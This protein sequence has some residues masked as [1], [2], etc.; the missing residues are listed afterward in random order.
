TIM[1]GSW[2]VGLF[3][4]L[5]RVPSH[6]GAFILFPGSY[7]NYRRLFSVSPEV[8]KSQVSPIEN[9]GPYMEFLAEPGDAVIF[10]HAMGHTGSTNITNPQTRLALLTRYYPRPR[11]CPG[12]KP[13][14]AMSTIEKANSL[15]YFRERYGTEFSFP[16]CD[17]DTRLT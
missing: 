16:T 1:P 4:F 8:I 9:S 5:T 12:N 13:L 7:R 3:V 2:A 10:H 11:I 15:R 14:E 6:G 17:P